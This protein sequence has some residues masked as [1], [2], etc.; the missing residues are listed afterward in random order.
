MARQPLMTDA[1]SRK[2]NEYAA[3]VEKDRAELLRQSVQAVLGTHAGR[4][5]F[6]ELLERAGIYQSIWTPNAEIH[7]RAG[8]QDFGHELQAL[9]VDAN[10]ELYEQMAREA[11]ARVKREERASA[12]VQVETEDSNG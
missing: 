7:Y 5:V 10:E 4:L 6:W 2:Q 8:R 9:L 11:R 3:R 12:A 1:S